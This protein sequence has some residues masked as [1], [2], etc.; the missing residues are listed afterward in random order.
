MMEEEQ[1]NSIAGPE[2]MAAAEA[3]VRHSDG[4]SYAE[5]LGAGNFACRLR[6]HLEIQPPNMKYRILTGKC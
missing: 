2:A 4:V 5:A 1:E 3:V 6:R